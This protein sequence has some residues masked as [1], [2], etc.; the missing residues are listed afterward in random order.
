MKLRNYE[1]K[2]EHC[3]WHNFLKPAS[4]LS[5]DGMSLW[6]VKDKACIKEKVGNATAVSRMSFL[7]HS[8]HWIFSMDAFLVSLI[9]VESFVES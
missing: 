6:N 5:W 3:N 8:L 4:Y 2:S 1:I 9:L 7:I